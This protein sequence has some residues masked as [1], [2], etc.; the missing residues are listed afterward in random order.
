[1]ITSKQR[2]YLRGLANNIP[3][4]C[5]LGKDGIGENLTK[6]LDDALTAREL[7]KTHVL[8]N[9][10]VTARE[11]CVALADIL[12]AEIVSVVGGRFVLYRPHPKKE[13]RQIILPKR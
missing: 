3:T 6:Q 4:I 13:K 12:H 8:D 2:A 5:Q 11:A 7:V 10:P 1:M 9:A